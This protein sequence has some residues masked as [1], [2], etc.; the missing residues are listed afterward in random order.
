MSSLANTLQ[1]TAGQ[2]MLGIVL[3]LAPVYAATSID[4]GGLSDRE[5]YAFIDGAIGAGNLVGGFVVGLIGAR[6]GLGRMVIAG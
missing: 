1:A 3:A 5:A 2:F 4:R 6:L